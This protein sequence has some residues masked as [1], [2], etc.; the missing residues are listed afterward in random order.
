[1]YLLRTELGY[2]GRSDEH[3]I[4][5]LGQL[6]RAQLGDKRHSFITLD[7]EPCGSCRQFLHRLEDHTDILFKVRVCTELGPVKRQDGKL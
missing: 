1:M 2:A 3:L 4:S 5:K 7:K 6:T